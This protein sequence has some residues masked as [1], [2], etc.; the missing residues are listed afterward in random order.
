MEAIA[1]RKRINPPRDAKPNALAGKVALITGSSSGIGAAVARELSARGA[2]VVINYGWPDLQGAANEVGNSLNTPWI[3]VEADTSTVD[4]PAKLVKATVDK[5][6][7][8]DII[9]NYAAKATLAQVED[10]TVNLWDTTM[11]TN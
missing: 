11:N 8:I 4:G 7:K 3:A 9:V 1:S 5:F 10:T 2:S 6:G